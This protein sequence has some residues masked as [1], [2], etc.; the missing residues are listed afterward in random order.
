MI[1]EVSN[2]KWLLD[3]LFV[4]LILLVFLFADTSN[5]YLQYS[6]LLVIFI[7]GVFIRKNPFKYNSKIILIFPL[8]LLCCWVYGV[9]L[10]L[11]YNNS[12]VFINNVG[13]LFFSSF[14]FFNSTPLRLSDF[15]KIFYN[16]SIISIITYFYSVPNLFNS[17]YSFY[18]NFLFG[19]RFAYNLVGIFPFVI[20]PILVFNIFFNKNKNLLI[21]SSFLNYS[22][23]VLLLMIA[24]FFVASKGIYFFIVSA[25]F[26]LFI[27]NIKKFKF[28]YLFL[29]IG[30]LLFQNIS[31]QITIFG[32]QDPS[33]ENRYMQF[34]AVINELTFLGKGWG[35]KYI[36]N[37]LDRDELGYSI[38]LSYLN[39]V[40]KIG[41]FSIV[42]F[43]FYSYIFF[44]I[45][46]LL[47]SKIIVSKELGLFTLGL[48]CYLFIS[49]G[50]PSLFAP[51]FVFSNSI[52]LILL[53]KVSIYDK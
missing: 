17:L 5:K 2:K 24:I 8:L 49:I 51:I 22:L 20:F 13:I 16:V 44:K 1:N 11:F 48:T 33:N 38:E 12:Y 10:G 37:D 53:N 14:Y 29:F 41:I 42:F 26:L 27:T 6:N 36:S 45:Y 18:L 21:K 50:N 34:D 43:V 28:A 3:K 25:F 23:F 9:I 39:L 47:K 52:L 15:F 35:A 19:N 7:Y 4:Y 32:D 40:H 30:F 31:D 46:L